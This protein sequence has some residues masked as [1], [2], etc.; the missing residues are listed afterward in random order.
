MCWDGLESSEQ[1]KI[2]KM[3]VEEI[4]Y[5]RHSHEGRLRVRAEVAGEGGE[6]VMIHAGRRPLVQQAAPEKVERPAVTVME[7]GLPRITKLMAL[8]IR[9]EGL[10]QEGAS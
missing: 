5:D 8:A 9:M 10:L 4:L 7:G 3:A 1:Q 2:M 6:E